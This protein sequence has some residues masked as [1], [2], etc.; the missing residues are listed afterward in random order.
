MVTNDLDA[1]R[2]LPCRELAG[3]CRRRHYSFGIWLTTRRTLICW[4]VVLV[5]DVLYLIVFYREHLK[6]DALLQV[7][8][9]ASRFIAGGIG[10][11]GARWRA[12]CAWFQCA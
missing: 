8:F 11:R 5:S 1:H 2:E 9:I 6:S 4:P 7:F 12:R 10:A 3:D